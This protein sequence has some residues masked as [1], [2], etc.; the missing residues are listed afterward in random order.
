MDDRDAELMLA[1][2]DGDQDAFEALVQRHEAG[3]INFLFR[4]TGDRAAAEDLGQEVFIRVYRARRAY[5]PTARFTTWLYRVAT[6]AALNHIR[7]QGR[8]VLHSLDARRSSGAP[9][10]NDEA[11]AFDPEDPR[12]PQPADRL[13][14][15][16]LARA[17][18]AA[19]DGLPP[20]Q[21]AAVLLN[22]FHGF[23]YGDV[24]DA[25]DTTVPAVKSLLSRAQENLRDSLRVALRRFEPP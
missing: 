25:L 3:V 23:S 22:R 6:N 15:D 10:D 12:M 13:A 19:V 4:F 20:Q 1:V 24:A 14:D 8:A 18:R 21:R 17:V 7:D 5:R 9:G 2:R 11:G 16:E